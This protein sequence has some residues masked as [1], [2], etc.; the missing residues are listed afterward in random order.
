[1]TFLPWILC[2]L[3]ISVLWLI[4]GPLLALLWLFGAGPGN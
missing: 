1:M 2:C 4:G 3:F